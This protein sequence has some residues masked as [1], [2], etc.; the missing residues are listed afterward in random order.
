M[1]LS[2]IIPTLNEEHH[3]THLLDSLQNVNAEIIVCDGGSS[4]KTVE[5]ARSYSNVKVI[6][7]K[8]GRANQMNAGAGEALGSILLF[9]HA[10]SILS[11]NAIESLPNLIDGAVPGAFQLKFDQNGWLLRVYEWFSKF[12]FSLTT[13]GDQGLL[14]NKNLYN[15][16]GGYQPYPIMEDIDMVRRI[17]KKSTFKKFDAAIITSARRFKA[18]GHFKQQVINI[19][20][21]MGFYFGISPQFLSRFYRY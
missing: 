5:L 14:I 13:Y 7:A 9:L 6:M 16:L 11:K 17:R 21:V 12:N 10:D 8:K 18:H 15:E 1:G 3:I 4:D 19:M 20:L 2:V